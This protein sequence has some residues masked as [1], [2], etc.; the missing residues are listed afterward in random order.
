MEILN[1][2][3]FTSFKKPM[4]FTSFKK[5]FFPVS[6]FVLSMLHFSTI[7]D[8]VSVANK[9]ETDALLNWKARL[10][11]ENQSLKLSWTLLPNSHLCFHG[12]SFRIMQPMLPTIKMQAQIHAVGLVFLATMQ[13]VLSD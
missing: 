11:N 9:T 5:V 8:S 1:H 2:I 3:L 6:L 10:Q 12:L 13:E 4:S 7:A